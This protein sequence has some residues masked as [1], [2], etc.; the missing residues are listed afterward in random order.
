MNDLPAAHPG[1]PARVR[2][3]K[4][5]FNSFERLVDHDGV[6]AGLAQN[7]QTASLPSA[8]TGMVRDRDGDAVVQSIPQG[9]SL[10][11]DIRAL[12]LHD[13]PP[14]DGAVVARKR[15][16]PITTK[17][18]A[19]VTILGPLEKRLEAPAQEV[20]RSAGKEGQE[21]KGGGDGC[22]FSAGQQAIR[23]PPISLRSRFW[24]HQGQDDAPD[25]RRSRKRPRG[26]MGRDRNAEGASTRTSDEGSPPWQQQKQ[27]RGVPAVLHS[28]SLRLLREWQARES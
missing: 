11:G 17:G 3:R 21:E 19:E 2:F 13:N 4:F 18:G 1:N 5:W 20:D 15:D 16:K 6:P 14:F 25:G 9:I 10:S 23:R 28:G 26:G 22:S 24:C 8:L 27:P 12:G 7:V